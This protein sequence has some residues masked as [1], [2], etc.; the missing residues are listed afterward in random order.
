M[1]LVV[2]PHPVRQ[3]VGVGV[4]VVDESAVLDD[5]LTGMRRV[6]AGVPAQRRGSGELLQDLYG[7]GHMGAL[8]VPVDQLIGLPPQ[9]MAS[10]LVAELAECGHCLGVSLHGQGDG[11]DGER[12]AAPSNNRRSRHSP[13]RDPYS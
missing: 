10:D 2:H 11:E 13:A 8:G 9:A 1:V 5:K 6:A 3:V 4:G 12:Y 7:L